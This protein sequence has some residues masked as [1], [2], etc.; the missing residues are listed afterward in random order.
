[1]S[2][3]DQL[4]LPNAAPLAA[5]INRYARR[6]VFRPGM[7]EAWVKHNVEEVGILESILPPLF[8]RASASTPA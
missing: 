2:A 7:A 4:S 3:T 5:P 8:N 1:M 6:N